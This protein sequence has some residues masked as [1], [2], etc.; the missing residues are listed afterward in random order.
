MNS[1]KSLKKIFKELSIGDYSPCYRN[2]LCPDCHGN[3]YLI[4]PAYPN[5]QDKVNVKCS[6]CH[7]S[8]IEPNI[9]KKNYLI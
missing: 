6:M 4:R 8:W 5:C 1:I 3:N 2:K 9:N 7:L